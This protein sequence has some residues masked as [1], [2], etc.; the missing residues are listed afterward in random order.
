MMGNLDTNPHKI[1]QVVRQFEAVFEN[2]TYFVEIGQNVDA[3][4]I[5]IC[6]Y[7]MPLTNCFLILINQ[8]NSYMNK[9]L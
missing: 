9:S 1:A 2:D 6:A 7:A 8:I 4:F 5:C 3:A